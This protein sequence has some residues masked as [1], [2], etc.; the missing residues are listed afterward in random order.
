MTCAA[1]VAALLSLYASPAAAMTIWDGTAV[2]QWSGDGSEASPYLITTPQELA[3][4]AARTNEGEAFEGKYFR[5]TAD[6]WLSDA[7]ADND[8]KPLWVPIGYRKGDMLPDSPDYELNTFYFKGNF[9]GGGHTIHNLY[10]SGESSIESWDDLFNEDGIDFNGWDKALFGSLDGAT[11]SNLRLDNAWILGASNIAGIACEAANSTISDVHVSGTFV[12]SNSA[13][14]G[15]AAGIVGR[16]SNSELVRCVADVKARGV[17]GVGGIVGSIE[18]ASTVTDCTS[19]GYMYCTQYYVGGLVGYVSEGSVVTKCHSSADVSRSGYTYASPDVAPFVG[20]NNGT[21]TLCYATGNVDNARSTGAG[22]CGT[23]TG[24]IESCYATGNVTVNAA[25]PY[26]ASFVVSNGDRPINAFEDTPGIIRNC[27][28]TGSCRSTVSD[29]NDFHRGGFMAQTFEVSETVNC[30]FNSDTNSDPQGAGDEL[31]LYPGEFGLTTAQI[32]DGE[33][34]RRLNLVAPVA[35]LS[36]WTADSDG[37]PVPTGVMAS[38]VSDVFGGGNGT[39]DNP[40]LIST[41]AHLENLATVCNSGWRFAGQHLLQSADIALNAPMEQWGEEMPAVWVPIGRYPAAKSGNWNSYRFCGSYDGA[42]HAVAN[43]YI[44]ELPDY[45]VG[46]FG[47]L[48]S[49]AEVLNL[50]ITDAWIEAAQVCGAVAGAAGVWNDHDN[51][52]RLIAGCR[53]GGNITAKFAASGILGGANYNNYTLIAA[54]SSTAGVDGGQYSRPFF[55]EVNSTLA[56]DELVIAGSWFAGTFPAPLSA[57][58]ENRYFRSYVIDTALGASSSLDAVRV[59]AERLRSATMVNML[60][61]ATAAVGVGAS[62]WQ[63]IENGMPAFTGGTAPTVPVTL[64]Y[65][66]GFAPLEYLAVKGARIAMP[67]ASERDGWQLTAWSDADGEV[68]RF[69]RTAVEEAL[70]LTA[71][72]NEIIMPDYTLFKNKFATTFTVTTAA[73]LA[74]LSDIV[75]GKAEGVDKNDFAGKTVKLGADIVLNDTDCDGWGEDSSPLSFKPIGGADGAFAGTFNGAGHTV[76]GLYVP[77]GYERAGMFGTLAAGAVVNDLRITNSMAES[78]AGESG[79]LAGRSA[80]RIERVGVD[81]IV[82]S[83]STSSIFQGGMIG[84]TA[85]GSEISQCYA[86]VT[87]DAS[88]GTQGGLVGQNAGPI[89]DSYA[90]GHVVNASYGNY[91]GIVGATFGNAA[92]PIGVERCYAAMT[93]SWNN[94]YAFWPVDLKIGGVYG[95]WRGCMFASLYYDRGLVGTSMD[96]W[97]EHTAEAL[98]SGTPLATGDMHKMTSF[99]DFDFTDV[100][101]RRNDLN[102]GY[103]YLRW[104]APGLENDPDYN[105]VGDIATDADTRREVFTLQGVRVYTGDGEPCRLAPGVYI[106]RTARGTRK[107]VVK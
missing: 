99:E 84:V 95:A 107:V 66:E 75:A 46:L 43:M 8:T 76:S 34:M 28:A 56:A 92:Q 50:D 102:D 88:A 4:L 54:C 61:Y 24:I 17:R 23:N 83:R 29:E 78:A 42:H 37:Y 47:V 52:S 22:F 103:P 1:A 68:F 96:G 19:S 14:G 5:L 70:V 38:D 58:S 15:S 80:A 77:A 82:R 27:Y 55:A 85:V 7:T 53:T 21:I 44:A 71:R 3:G 32:K 57:V 91:G 11:V 35:G 98:A 48:G 73:Q 69:S 13:V 89:A 12:S 30:Y 40:Y 18:K 45:F 41:K 2:T 25:S 74:G 51:G 67:V 87:L 39:A 36:L 33:L 90:R 49:G 86:L 106:E 72:W 26:M 31:G 16:I 10:Y 93:Y 60:N 104:T 65:G 105:A 101:G 97:G 9:D 81:G 64:N 100:W 20:F 62:R 94:P 63:W 6:L 79:I 59:T